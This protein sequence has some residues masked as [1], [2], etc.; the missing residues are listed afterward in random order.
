MPDS[1]SA[2]LSFVLAVAGF[3]FVPEF[4]NKPLSRI[5]NMRYRTVV[6]DKDPNIIIPDHFPNFRRGNG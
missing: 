2:G 5:A 1:V 3:W 4:L 6:T